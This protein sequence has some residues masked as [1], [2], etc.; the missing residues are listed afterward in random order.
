[1]NPKW[2]PVAVTLLLAVVCLLYVR[3]MSGP[4][5]FDDY[6]NIVV[7]DAVTPETLSWDAILLALTPS[8]SG[9]LGRPVAMLTFALNHA[10]LGPLPAGYK[11]VNILVHALTTLAVYRFVSLLTTVLQ[12]RGL[13]PDEQRYRATLPL[14][15]AAVWA[16]NPLQLTSVLYPVQRMTSLA[17]LFTF[18]ALACY[19]QARLSRGWRAVAAYFVAFFVCMP[20]GVLSKEPAAL[21]PLLLAVVEYA[22]FQRWTPSGQH[23]RLARAAPWLLTGVPAALFLAFMAFNPGWIAAGYEV[24]DFTMSQRLLTEPRAIWFYIRLFFLPSNRALGLYHDDFSVSTGLLDPPI[25]ALAGA[26]IVLALTAAIRF[27]SR[28]PWLSFAVLF[29]LAGHSLESTIFPLELVHEHRNYVPSLGLAFG[30]AYPLVTTG[31]REPIFHLATAALVVCFAGITAMRATVWGDPVQLLTLEAHH[32]PGSARANYEAGHLFARAA[33]RNDGEKR[34]HYYRVA[35]HYFN[36]S[37]INPTF[38]ISYLALIWLETSLGN[39]PSEEIANAAKARL[40]STPMGPTVVRGL[41][42]LNR[43]RISLRCAISDELV[44]DLL[45][46]GL[47]SEHVRPSAAALLLNE[48]AFLAI[49]RDGLPA[50]AALTLQAHKLSPGDPQFALNYVELLISGGRFD[51]A[52]VFIQYALDEHPR[53]TEDQRKVVAR[54]KGA[55]ALR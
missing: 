25:T 15:T 13:L 44:R 39:E 43:C 48:L 24:R 38:D 35:K 51:E 18:A 20:L 27:R 21:I 1:V 28:L 45:L 29:F 49:E 10:L 3:G 54:Q 33:L 6:H 4:F 12:R 22:V 2:A 52:R 5:L 31:L 8:D 36:Q 41:Q 17:A 55:V 30:L 47:A 34:L 46:A 19:I 37:S 14:V 23:I 9:P 11:L 53:L 42:D 7:N 40:R 50:A 16:L 32:H 26:G